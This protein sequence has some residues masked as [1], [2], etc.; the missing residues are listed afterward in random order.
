V[1]LFLA[2]AP[3]F[4]KNPLKKYSVVQVGGDIVIECK[5]NAFPRATISWKRGIESLRQSK[6]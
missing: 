6:R 3:D 4:S 1:I 5:P 2:S